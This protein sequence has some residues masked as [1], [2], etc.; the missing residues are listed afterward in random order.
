MLLRSPRSGYQQLRR[1]VTLFDSLRNQ[2]VPINIDNQEALSWYCC[3]PTVYDSAHVGHARCVTHRCILRQAC[4]HRVGALFTLMP[5]SR[6]Y[7][8]FDIARR[9]LERLLQKPVVYVMGVTDVDD[10][11]IARSTELGVPVAAVAA[12]YEAEFMRDMAALGVRPPT[13][14]VRVSEHVDAI[15][16]HIRAIESRGFAYSAPDG[17]GV[18]LDT[19]RMGHAYGKLRP[20]QH[21]QGG[22]PPP[23]STANAT[24][25]EPA[26]KRSPAD[27]ALWKAAKA[28]EA[29]S[30]AA[31]PSPWGLGRPGWHVECSAMVTATLGLHVDV[32]S[33]G[34]DLAFPHH[35]NEVAQAECSHGW[36]AAEAEAQA[37]GGEEAEVRRWV[38][39]WLHAGH[40]HLAGRKM[41]KS[42][43][44]FVTVE[45]LL[46]P[47]RDIHDALRAVASPASARAGGGDASP[48]SGSAFSSLASA[49]DRADAFRLYCLTHSYRSDVALVPA[50]LDEAAAL[51]LRLRRALRAIVDAAMTGP[52]CKEAAAGGA[53]PPCA[54]RSAH[55][56]PLLAWPDELPTQQQQ[57]PQQPH[58]P[59]LARQ[60]ELLRDARSQVDASLRADLGTPAALRAVTLLAGQAAASL[61]LEGPPSVAGALLAWETAHFVADWLACFGLAF[62]HASLAALRGGGSSNRGWPALLLPEAAVAATESSA[63]VDASGG[64]S[65][66]PD[67]LA[68]AGEDP[69]PAVAELVAFRAAVRREA[70]ALLK[71]AKKGAVATA[72]TGKKEEVSAVPALPQQGPAVANSNTNSS[73]SS[74]ASDAAGR[75]MALCD[76]L[77]DSAL[78]RLGWKLSDRN[79]QPVVERAVAAPPAA[80]KPDDPAP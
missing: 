43:K 7:V 73:S 23:L 58:L 70:V 50:Q 61:A 21:G 45:E 47:G 63:P 57:Q 5:A 64:A 32:H 10:K 3:G 68:G 76:G 28:G 72:A 36:V 2:V 77:R 40:V 71:A 16:D 54:S 44:N 19:G 34:V 38:R 6:T 56:G 26:A 59:L 53:S 74:A 60:R 39:A 20:A 17:S 51:L 13:A 48:S 29:A 11:I 41:S 4:G 75:L 22:T 42:L 66:V 1:L 33:G 15:I 8:C 46:Q 62:P 79:G 49:A 30:G 18:Y 12:R 65:R 14:V 37:A 69:P 9:V 24:V 55:P 80:L 27:C 35:C 52:A 25:S 31:W 67:A 78:P